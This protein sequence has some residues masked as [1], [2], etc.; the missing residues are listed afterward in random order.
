MHNRA[1][2]ELSEDGEN[3]RKRTAR[4]HYPA[5]VEHISE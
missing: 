2:G 5:P 3:L 4:K 1:T